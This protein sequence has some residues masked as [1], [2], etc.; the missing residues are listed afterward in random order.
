VGACTHASLLFF[1]LGEI[2]VGEEGFEE[3]RFSE[4][5][6]NESR[7]SGEDVDVDVDAGVTVANDVTV[8]IGVCI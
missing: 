7:A 2:T 1:A 6:N 3:L 5:D 4:I 8:A